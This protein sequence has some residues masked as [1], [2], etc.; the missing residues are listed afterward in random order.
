MNPISVPVTFSPHIVNGKPRGY[1][2]LVQSLFPNGAPILRR[3]QFVGFMGGHLIVTVSRHHTWNTLFRMAIH[4]QWDEHSVTW[5][6]SCKLY[7]MSKGFRMYIP[8]TVLCPTSA[9]SKKVETMGI[10]K[11]WTYGGGI[12]PMFFVELP[13]VSAEV[14]LGKER[15][16]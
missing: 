6:D 10:F 1:Y 8:G 15:F 16:E 12:E 4:P 11:K 5:L 9:E 2:L 13:V 14:L 3:D 7:R